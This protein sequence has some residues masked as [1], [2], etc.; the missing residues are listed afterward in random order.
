M[1]LTNRVIIQGDI[2]SDIYYDLFNINGRQV[3]F[4]RL[5]MMVNETPDAKEVNGLRV[6]FYGSKAEEAEAFVQKGTRILV[7][8]HIQMRRAPNG[9]LTFEVVAEDAEYLRNATNERGQKRK[10]EMR[11]RA[12]GVKEKGFFVTL[13]PD[14]PDD[15]PGV[16]L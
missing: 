13:L 15:T 2:T 12:P 6:V 5:Y 8:G 10:E 3:P 7:E 9:N 1:T 14:L 4:L 11:A 16:N